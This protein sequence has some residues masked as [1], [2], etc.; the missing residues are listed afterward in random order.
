MNVQKQYNKMMVKAGKLLG[1]ACDGCAAEGLEFLSADIRRLHDRV[2]AE[3]VD[4][5]CVVF[6]QEE[7]DAEL[8]RFVALYSGEK[9]KTEV[10]VPVGKAWIKVMKLANRFEEKVHTEALKRLA[11]FIA[12]GVNPEAT[13]SV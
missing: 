4:L 8:A 7:I 9:T 11:G 1:D 12:D 5:N 10:I 13:A 6:T 3:C 2:T